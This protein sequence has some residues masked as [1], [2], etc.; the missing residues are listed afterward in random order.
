[1]VDE[2]QMG[3]G[4]VSPSTRLTHLDQYESADER[5]TCAVLRWGNRHADGKILLG[6]GREDLSAQEKQIL[7]DSVAR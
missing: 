6:R 1:M 5:V 7:E 4:F 3:G 2:E